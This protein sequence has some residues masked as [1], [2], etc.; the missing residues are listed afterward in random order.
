MITFVQAVQRY[1]YPLLCWNYCCVHFFASSF[2]FFSGTRCCV[3]NVSARA[4]RLLQFICQRPSCDSVLC[5]M[6]SPIPGHFP[7]DS[8]DFPVRSRVLENNAEQNVR[9]IPHALTNGGC[10]ITRVSAR[11]FRLLFQYSYMYKLLPCRIILC[12]T[13]LCEVNDRRNRRPRC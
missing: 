12:A 9:G 8:H 10:A 7:C 6:H 5:R 13:P 11:R 3:G 4:C 1:Q 2:R